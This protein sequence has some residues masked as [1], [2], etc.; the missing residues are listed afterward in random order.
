M[1]SSVI[2]HF[3]VMTFDRY[4]LLGLKAIMGVH[5]QLS[6]RAGIGMLQTHTVFV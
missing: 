2:M 4:C 6:W 5:L 1:C 3:T